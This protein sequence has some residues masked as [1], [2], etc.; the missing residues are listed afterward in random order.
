MTRLTSAR[1]TWEIRKAQ[2]EGGWQ[3]FIF[4]TKIIF[5]SR[6]DFDTAEEYADY[7]GNKEAM[8][9]A[10]FQYGMKM[11]DGRKTRGKVGTKKNEKAKLDREWNQILGVINKRK[12]G[13]GGG[14]AKKQKHNDDD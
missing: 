14:S 4:S 7:M 9:K 11:S 1:W 13:E 2:W 10:A 8:P 3:V 12:G 6:W 5:T